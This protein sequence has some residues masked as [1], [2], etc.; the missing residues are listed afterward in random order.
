MS[1]RCHIWGIT[2][3]YGKA[4][5]SWVCLTVSVYRINP[6]SSGRARWI[7]CHLKI[8]WAPCLFI[9][10]SYG[11]EFVVV[12]FFPLV[13]QNKI[14]VDKL[15]IPWEVETHLYKLVVSSE[16]HGLSFWIFETLDDAIFQ[17][18]GVIYSILCNIS[19]WWGQLGGSLGWLTVGISSRQLSIIGF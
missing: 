2:S 10:I 8:R 17:P 5:L 13:L 14:W 9:A 4:I 7:S 6:L 12:V 3:N 18:Y 19:H 15:I 11:K 1:L 16:F